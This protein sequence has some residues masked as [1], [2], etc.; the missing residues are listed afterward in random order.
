MIF[1]VLN[2]EGHFEA[3]TTFFGFA[4]SQEIAMGYGLGLFHYFT[5]RK[6]LS[7]GLLSDPNEDHMQKLCP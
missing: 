6:D 4:K 7:N 3:L 1:Q 2:F 5:S